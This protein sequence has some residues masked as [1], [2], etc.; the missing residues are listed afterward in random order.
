MINKKTLFLL[1]LLLTLNIHSMHNKRRLHFK[2]IR[3]KQRIDTYQNQ[4]ERMRYIRYEN[5]DR[6]RRNN[7][8]NCCTNINVKDI[9]IVL[10]TLASL[11]I[12]IAKFIIEV[13]H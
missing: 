9:A 2:K 10:V 13:A 7:Q 11:G 4:R 5:R 1:F 8:I 3:L 12:T 6:E